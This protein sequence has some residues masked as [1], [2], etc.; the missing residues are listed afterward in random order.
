MSSPHEQAEFCRMAIEEFDCL[1][2]KM[3]KTNRR[4]GNEKPQRASHS[5]ESR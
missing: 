3:N 1:M 5:P 2:E 4:D